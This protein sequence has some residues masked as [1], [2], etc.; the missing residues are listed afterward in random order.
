MS[1]TNT[2]TNT[3]AGNTNR[4]HNAGR[5]GRGQGGSGG[6]G[7]GGR[8]NDCGKT[9]A[10]YSFEG[11]MKVGPLSKL[12]IT[13]GGQQAT[14]YKKILD[15]LP[16]LAADKGYKYINDIIRTDKE[17]EISDF[18]PTYPLASQWSTTY[19]V[20]VVT[21]NPKATPDP[22]TKKRPTV[23][24]LQERT[25]VHNPD[26]QKKLLLEHDLKSKIQMRE[27]YK[28]TADK[29]ALMT[30]IYGQCDDATRTEIS[31]GAR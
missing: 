4:N 14:Q 1:Q 7:R 21:V 5:G 20:E 6:R 26:L 18:T 15:A 3:G 23:I 13:E 12:T 22:T 2:N 31:I 24:K 25:N 30:I 11:K 9:V 28:L 16:V 19:H 8:R 10:E 27:W 17:K 29:K